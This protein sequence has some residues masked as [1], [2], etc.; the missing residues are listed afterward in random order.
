MRAR[1]WRSMRNAGE[2]FE[3]AGDECARPQTVE[4]SPDDDDEED[5]ER[6]QRDHRRAECDGEPDGAAG[7]VVERLT[8]LELGESDLVADQPARVV[9]ESANQLRDADIGI[10]VGHDA[11]CH[12]GV[13]QAVGTL[14]G[15]ARR[16][17]RVA[18]LGS[19]GGGCAGVG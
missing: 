13:L 17:P 14:R 7:P 9:S 18:G 11:G 19:H 8:E 15:G 3:G 16:G 10:G 2:Q 4:Q 6:R 1:P 12:V 5:R